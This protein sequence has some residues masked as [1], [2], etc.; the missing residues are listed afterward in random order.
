MAAVSKEKTA[1][2]SY[3]SHYSDYCGVKCYL[4]EVKE[5][6]KNYKLGVEGLNDTKIK[7]VRH[8]KQT[9]I[10]NFVIYLSRVMVLEPKLTFLEP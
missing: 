6:I 8:F 10:H 5:F 4:F 1:E 7:T 9:K 3:H 2:I